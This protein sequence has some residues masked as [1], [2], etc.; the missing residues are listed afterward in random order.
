MD[1]KC[2]FIAVL[3]TCP[4]LTS[5][6]RDVNCNTQR[7]HPHGTGHMQHC[8]Q[9]HNA[10]RL[11]KIDVNFQFVHHSVSGSKNSHCQLANTHTHTHTHR[12]PTCQLNRHEFE[13]ILLGH[14]I[15]VHSFVINSDGFI[16]NHTNFSPINNI[17]LTFVSRRSWICRWFM[18]AKNVLQSMLKKLVQTTWFLIGTKEK[19]IVWT[20]GQ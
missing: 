17:Y 6:V 12:W 5:R 11:P 10:W 9:K 15:H 8:I 14:L 3:F 19:L 4:K 18:Y 1:E 13:G 7:I 20:T 16:K 2:R